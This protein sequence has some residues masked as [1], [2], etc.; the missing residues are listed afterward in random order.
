MR[1]AWSCTPEEGI[2]TEDIFRPGPGKAKV[3]T[4]DF[5]RAV[6]ERL[7]KLPKKIKPVSYAIR[8][9]VDVITTENLYT[10]DRQRS[11]SLVQGQ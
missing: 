2:H 5:A 3:G 9:D 4:R 7:G 10:F 8:N 11:Y 1:K 6:I